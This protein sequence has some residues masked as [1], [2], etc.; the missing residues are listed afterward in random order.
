M[1]PKLLVEKV[2]DKEAEWPKDIR[3]PHCDARVLH[4]PEECMFCADAKEL[5]KERQDLNVSNTGH[6]NRS[7][8]CP[9]DKARSS[10]SL[11]SWGGNRPSTKEQW[12]A[13]WKKFQEELKDYLPDDNGIVRI[14]PE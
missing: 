3:F 2:M 12:E 7:W 11:N 10:E 1:K 6:A 8:P 13:D 4:L 9:A 5:Q 14:K